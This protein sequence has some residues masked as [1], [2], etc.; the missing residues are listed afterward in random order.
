MYKVLS[1]V[2][3]RADCWDVLMNWGTREKVSVK[4]VFFLTAMKKFHVLSS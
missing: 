2:Y 3:A 1:D 4:V